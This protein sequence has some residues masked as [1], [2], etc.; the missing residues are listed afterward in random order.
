MDFS[1]DAD[2]SNFTISSSSEEEYSEDNKTE[3]EFEEDIIED[4]ATP[5][6]KD[7][8]IMNTGSKWLGGEDPLDTKREEK[9]VLGIGISV[10]RKEREQLK[11][12]DKK[13][14]YK[15]RE[16]CV[17]GIE[18][19]FTQLKS[20]DE[21]S[22]IEHFESI[23][24]VVTRFDDLQESL[25]T[26][27]MIDVFTIGSDYGDDG[28]GPTATAKEIDLFHDV[29][30]VDMGIVKL[31]NQYFMEYG[32]T[33]HG[34]NVTWSG[35]KILNSCDSTLRDKIIETTRGWSP[36]H[37]GGPTYLKI[38]MS[39]I[40]ATSKKSLRSLLN[41]VANLKLSDFNGE[42]VGKAVSFLRGAALILRDNDALPTDF[43]NMTL[44][45]F[46]HTSTADFKSYVTLL[47]NN[48]ELK[49]AKFH[50][51]DVLRLFEGKY[52]DMLGRN[53]WT[54]K[55]TTIDQQSGFYG[56]GKAIMC[57][58]CGGL[59]HT[60]KE[61][62]HDLDQEAIDI[63][64]SLVFPKRKGKSNGGSVSGGSTNNGSNVNPSSNKSE[65]GRKKPN[66]LL[67]PPKAGAPHE[68]VINGTKLFWCGKEGCCKWGGHKSADHPDGNDDS[69]PQGHHADNDSD[70]SIE[71]IGDD[72]AGMILSASSTNF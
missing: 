48:I 50:L 3:F 39:L 29:K 64:K 49:L 62:P 53:E 24:S 28:T 37:K 45:I 71:D 27:D 20:I 65:N 6:S 70:H 34:E 26:N 4:S 23:Y 42:D 56:T 35:E 54:A 2:L 41:K 59:M 58:N 68:K 40:V 67:Q 72:Y 9:D 66:P 33:Y 14:Y 15:V 25:R 13:T 36:L 57:F 5:S 17:K 69:S 30:E 18:N 11:Q 51:D 10:A 43:M 21:N 8:T 19:K 22:P 38:L 55:S 32:Q 46:K 1:F 61:C 63:R 12:T 31:A 44:K 52:I 60:I 16:N 47:E 7:I